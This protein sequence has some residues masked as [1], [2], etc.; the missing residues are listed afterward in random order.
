[1]PV[2]QLPLMLAQRHNNQQLFSGHYLNIT[3]AQRPEWKL[4]AHD[5]RPLLAE[6]TRIVWAYIPSRARLRP[7]RSRRSPSPPASP[8]SALRLSPTPRRS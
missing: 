6:V 7:R 8:P 3:L 1:M 2:I 5:A 4:L